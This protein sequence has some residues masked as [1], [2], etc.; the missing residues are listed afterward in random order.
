MCHHGNISAQA[1]FGAAHVP[2]DGR[3][4]RGT[5]QHGEILARWIFGTMNFQHRNIS[6][7]HGYF[8]TLQSNM[9]VSAQTFWHLCYC[10]KMSMCQNV[11]MPRHSCA[12]NSLNQK[13]PMSKCSHV[14][15][16]ICQNV[17]SAEWCTYLK[18]F[19][20]WNICA[21]MTL[22]KSKCSK[23]S[24]LKCWVGLKDDMWIEQFNQMTY[25]AL[26]SLII[27]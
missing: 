5:F 16:S 23:C 2:A 20:W 17:S 22:A 25:P 18:M 21:E 13:I 12:K 19:P 6:A 9:D 10:A 27:G 24:V 4:N 1:P 14:K 7:A 11:P 3:F 15:R 8:G 26:R